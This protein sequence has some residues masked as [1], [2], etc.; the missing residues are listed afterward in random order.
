MQ[1]FSVCCCKSFFSL[2]LL[3]GW[4]P[5]MSW[6][7]N[8]TTSYDDF[9]HCLLTIWLRSWNWKFFFSLS[10]AVVIWQ[11]FRKHASKPVFESSSQLFSE[12]KFC[13][14]TQVWKNKFFVKVLLSTYTQC[15]S[16]QSIQHIIRKLFLF[17]NCRKLFSRFSI[18]TG[19]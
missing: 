10:Q 12:T 7:K 11:H 19:L 6:V 3:V 8:T 17:L 18:E 13:L 14:R 1:Y 5:T 9:Q 2:L 16:F 4:W 15:K